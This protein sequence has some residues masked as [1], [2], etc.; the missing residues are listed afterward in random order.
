[1]QSLMKKGMT[2]KAYLEQMKSKRVFVPMNTGTRTFAS[3]KDYNRQRYK[4]GN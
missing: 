2:K 4:R 1:M 3:K